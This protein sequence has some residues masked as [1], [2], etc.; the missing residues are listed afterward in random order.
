MVD[1]NLKQNVF[2]PLTKCYLKSQEMLSSMRHRIC[3]SV[4]SR[5]SPN[6]LLTLAMG[7]TFGFS[8][9]YLLLTVINWEKVGL[10]GS[11]VFIPSSDELESHNDDPHD[12]HRL[13]SVSG[14]EQQVSIHSHDEDIHKGLDLLPIFN[15]SILC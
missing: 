12:H 9:A 6:F 2:N 1:R 13:D 15:D 5:V 11:Q 14:P 3:Q 7:M 4:N 8:F 10:N